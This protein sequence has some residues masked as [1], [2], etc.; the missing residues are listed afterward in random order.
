MYFMYTRNDIFGIINDTL[1]TVCAWLC[2]IIYGLISELYQLFTEMGLLFYNDTF[3]GIYNK[4]SLLIGVFM[5][6]RVAFWLIE[7]LVSPDKLTDKE[8][9]P[10]KIIQKVLVSV[11]LLA[12]TPTLF[13]YA[14]KFQYDIVNSQL[15]EKVINI[16][17]ELID[18]DETSRFLTAELFSGFYK[19][20]DGFENNACA[21]YTDTSRFYDESIYINF[22]YKGKDNISNWCLNQVEKIEDKN[23]II[24]EEYVIN[25]DAL[26]AVAVGA[27]VFVM[28]LMYCISVG[29]RYVQLIYLQIIA[30]IPIMCYLTPN[31]DNMLSKWVKQCT[32]T[33]LDLFIRIAIINFVIL[34]VRVVLQDN[35]LLKLP[36]N[37]FIKVF[38]I[39]GLLTFAKKAPDLIQE[40]LPKSVTKASGDFG[41]S[42]KKRTDAMLGG[43]YIYNATKRAPGFAIGGVAGALTGGTMGIRGGKGVG[44]RIVGGLSGAYRGFSTGSK[45]GNVFK[46][47]GEVKKNQAAQNNRLQQWR[48]NAGKS[49]DA[50][51]TF[52][53]WMSRRSD[54]AKR[55]MGF[56]TEGQYFERAKSGAKLASDAYKSS[57]DN[58]ISKAIEKQTRA[59]AF[60]YGNE[61]L[62]QLDQNR[63]TAQNAVTENNKPNLLSTVDGN[64]KLDA[65]L[66]STAGNAWL[67]A[68]GLSLSTNFANLTATQKDNLADTFMKKLQDEAYDADT[69]YKDKEKQYSFLYQIEQAAG[70]KRINNDP[71]Q[72]IAIIN[73]EKG[74]EEYQNYFATINSFIEKFDE[75]LGITS[76]NHPLFE[77]GTKNFDPKKMAE[78]MNDAEHGNANASQEL[79]NMFEDYDKIKA[80]MSRVTAVENDK[81]Q[82]NIANDKYNS[83]GGKH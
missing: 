72:D 38:L 24:T 64:R 12:I 25:F 66:G 41:L 65:F 29:T 37:F 80:L 32:T 28:I 4:I 46:N 23:G 16:E 81:Q 8:K 82:R 19:T 73:P 42:W 6:F 26:P 71:T 20:N 75:E 60:N 11:V 14:F 44:S 36:N 47:I 50:P 13:E 3:G 5:V 51:N 62:T 79:M 74:S 17:D 76:G 48:I 63:K 15:I 34:L 18:K 54:A 35:N 22:Y 10:A 9:S 67:T 83:S 58:G 1:R 77:H 61:T 57:K 68:N 2:E 70:I 56:E 69:K 31:K 27:F 53:D 40:L 33:Y 59:K 55:A 39:L 49:E 21:I 30:P 45:K 78:L 7:L 43:K 52:S